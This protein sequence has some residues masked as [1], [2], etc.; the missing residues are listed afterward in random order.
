VEFVPHMLDQVG[1]KV[2]KHQSRSQMHL[3][4]KNACETSR[5]L[6][7]DRWSNDGSDSMIVVIVATVSQVVDDHVVQDDVS[8]HD[9]PECALR[10]RPAR[11]S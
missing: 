1:L 5:C 3:P 9:Q 2:Q 4:M 10:V 6:I 11:N 8:T 7:V